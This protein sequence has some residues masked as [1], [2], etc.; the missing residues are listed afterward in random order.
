[1]NY[2]PDPDRAIDW[3]TEIPNEVLTRSLR[4]WAVSRAIFKGMP[5]TNKAF[6]LQF[7]PLVT[8]TT[9]KVLW[10]QRR[11]N[12]ISLPLLSECKKQFNQ[13]IGSSV[14]P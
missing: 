10:K 12:G 11:T 3:P 2:D 4:E 8:T 14:F 5:D 13:Y 1:M 9:K 6:M 7:K